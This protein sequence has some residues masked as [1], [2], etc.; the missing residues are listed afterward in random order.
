MPLS[1]L[2]EKYGK[3]CSA[4]TEALLA[5]DRK[6]RSRNQI[7]LKTRIKINS[8]EFGCMFKC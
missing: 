1:L 6:T 2:I 5:A 8:K 4:A 3:G 7:R